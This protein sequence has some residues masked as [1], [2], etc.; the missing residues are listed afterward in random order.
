MGDS[1]WQKPR[2]RRSGEEACWLGCVVKVPA[3][4]VS[5]E[6]LP[7]LNTQFSK[8]VLKIRIS[9]VEIGMVLLLDNIYWAIIVSPTLE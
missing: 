3:Y 7:Y 5:G 2:S 4:S 8:M 1:L 6:S 9:R